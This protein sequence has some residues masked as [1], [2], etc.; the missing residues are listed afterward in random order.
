MKEE[1]KFDIE[2]FKNYI[3]TYNPT[4]VLG[5]PRDSERI[6]N[7]IMYGIGLSIDNEKY[8]NHPGYIKF[9]S[10]LKD[11]MTYQI[12]K[13]KL[14]EILTKLDSSNNTIKSLKK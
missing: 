2:F 9:L 8:K 7:D 13:I 1:R 12:I 14:D 6:V 4:D 3:A 11:N 10:F 5:E